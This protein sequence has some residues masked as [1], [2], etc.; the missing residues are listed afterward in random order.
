MSLTPILDAGLLDINGSLLA[1]VI[2]FV[3]M[4]LILARFVYPPVM[5]AAEA[6]Q[7]QVASELAA[8]E[9]SRR[10]AEVQ[11][12]QARAELDEARKQAQEVI[13]GAGRSAEEIR[14]EARARAEEDARRLAEKARKDIEAAR[15]QAVDG[16]RAQVAD[17]VVLATQ[18]VVAQSI[19]TD[20]HRR[21]IQG[22]IEEVTRPASAGADGG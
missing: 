6:R 20:Q 19:D 4:I 9:D 15:Q 16:V 8:A 11:L 5:R 3:A 21:L 22:A 2:A 17:L 10:Q 13:S 1:E 18:K 14:S 7:K 12:Q